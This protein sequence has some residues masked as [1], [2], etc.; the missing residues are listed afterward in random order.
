M[1]LL[2]LLNLQH[3]KM[4]ANQQ[5]KR[6]RSGKDCPTITPADVIADF[7]YG[8]RRAMDDRWFRSGADHDCWMRILK[9]EHQPTSE[10]SSCSLCFS[11]SSMRLLFFSYSSFS[12]SLSFLLIPAP[13]TAFLEQMLASSFAYKSTVSFNSRVLFSF[14][15]QAR[16]QCHYLNVHQAVVHNWQSFQTVIL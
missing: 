2:F 8:S 11:F 13:P 1:I 3:G 15:L 14:L 12:S 9:E 4:A 6:S 10:Q 7:N 5:R 16:S